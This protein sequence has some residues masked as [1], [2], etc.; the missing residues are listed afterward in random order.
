MNSDTTRVL[1]S[2]AYAETTYHGNQNRN[3]GTGDT[4][5][6][7]FVIASFSYTTMIMNVVDIAFDFNL[8]IS[9]RK[10]IRH[11]SV[12]MQKFKKN[13]RAI[14]ER[15]SPFRMCTVTEV[16]AFLMPQV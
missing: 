1:G 9:T 11:E 5:A 4:F 8:D 15:H 10:L 13:V 2:P 14:L 3:I 7:F 6:E 16:C 12:N